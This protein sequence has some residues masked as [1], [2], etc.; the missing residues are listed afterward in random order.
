MGHD[1]SPSYRQ[2]SL[3]ARPCR[4][5]SGV[6]SRGSRTSRWS[7]YKGSISEADPASE[8]SRQIQEYSAQPNVAAKTTLQLEAELRTD[9]LAEMQDMPR[10]RV[11]KEEC[12]KAKKKESK[13]PQ[14]GCANKSPQPLKKEGVPQSQKRS[15]V[16]LNPQN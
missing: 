8:I 2:E 1:L 7:H 9:F 6:R 13:V 15:A 14:S 5:H 11:P 12:S 3:A 16:S 4:R 10:C